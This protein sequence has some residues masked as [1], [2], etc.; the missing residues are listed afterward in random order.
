MNNPNAIRHEP[1]SFLKSLLVASVSAAVLVPCLAAAQG[2]PNALL[3]E[4][5]VT[6]Q[7]KSAAEASQDVPIAIS[8]YSGD[9]VEAMFAVNLVDIGTTAPNV[10][11]AEQGT[12]PHTG[13]FIIRGMGTAGQSIPSSDPAVGVVQDGMPFG[14][15]YGV[16]TDLFDIESIEIL[17]GPQGTLFG[18]NVTGGA[19]I[20]R[21]TR[22]TEEF[23]GKVKGVIGSHGQKEISTVLT[24]PLADRWSGKLAVLAKDRDGLWDNVTLG[25]EHGEEESLIVR[26]ALK[27]TGDNYDL[28]LLTEYAKIEGDGMAPR[29]FFIFGE[30]IDPWA[31]NSTSTD[32]EGAIDIDWFNIV[33]EH[34]LDLAGGTLTTNVSYRDFEQKFWGDIDGAPGF[35]RFEF[36]EGTGLL[37]EQVAFETRWAG[38]L[39]DRLNM[40]VGVNLMDQEYTYRERRLVVDL[41]EQPAESTIEHA[42]AGLFAQA[43]YR[44]TDSLYLTLG[45]R[46]SY[47]KK[48][49]A[50][51]VI[52]DPQGVGTCS[53]V[54]GEIPAARTVD[55]G[56]C[57]QV[58]N[59]DESW[60]NFTPK[61]GLTWDVNE[62]VMAYTSY[63]RGFRSGGYNVRFADSSLVN[64]PDNP[65]ST[66][67][68]YDEEVV[69]A[70]E[71]GVKSELASGRVRMNV[72]L[73][74][75]EYDDL[76]RSANNQ[77][78]VQQIFNAASSTTQGFEFDIVAAI[79]DN[80]TLEFA[81]GYTD[82]E[83][84]EA[85]YLESARGLPA[86]S[87]KL[88][89]VPE[90]TTSAALTFD[91]SIGDAG[92][93][94][95][96]G[97]YSYMDEVASDDFNFLIVPD[98]EL[99]NA[100]VSYT[101][102][103]EN[104]KVSLFGRNLKDEVY[105]HFGFDNTS[106]GSRTVWL[107][108]PRTYGLEVVY[109]F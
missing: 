83:Y 29:N 98:Y 26:P 107:A 60:G 57:R 21:T 58:F 44:L 43:E 67:G 87:F 46:Y 100:S 101:N 109:N 104:L 32:T 72:A 34:N 28:T 63:T 68:P 86:S 74:Y 37:Q 18:R 22:P 103:A 97:S 24:G 27:Y 61:I 77:S 6:A 70:Y 56:D 41:L 80:V 31:D 45:G 99:Y 39:S 69:D 73:F 71:V 105:S 3:E 38:D 13:N 92:Y 5:M 75:N 89:M 11:L 96:R 23:E 81:H 62:Q 65:R 93:L 88:Q 66:P 91:H 94:T 1:R 50:I 108:P 51:G 85:A 95:W 15:I 84:D 33:L 10:H 59:D 54:I 35:N 82:A 9:K 53:V 25:G 90:N 48:D 64:T 76:Q 47:E 7:K 36:A 2:R 30:E 19:V 79:T 49:A 42:T 14:L 20:I 8:A 52:G 16:V 4:V 78:G 12:A 55:W 40:T 102:A 106:I 17:R